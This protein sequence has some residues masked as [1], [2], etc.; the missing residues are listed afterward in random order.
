MKDGLLRGKR[1]YV[2]EYS[3]KGELLS[4]IP[5]DSKVDRDNVVYKHN[6]V[7]ENQRLYNAMGL[8]ARQDRNNYELQNDFF[9]ENM[10]K[11]GPDVNSLV[12]NM[13]N[14]GSHVFRDFSLFALNSEK[15]SI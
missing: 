8:L 2:N 12:T 15:M 3:A 7:R 9:V 13:G 5:Y 10:K 1:K 11:L 6:I 4:K 14:E